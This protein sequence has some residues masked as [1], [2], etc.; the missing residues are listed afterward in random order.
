MHHLWKT[1]LKN[2]HVE[3]KQLGLCP[4]A[5]GGRHG[6]PAGHC[7]TLHWKD[8]ENH[9]Q[10]HLPGTNRNLGG[11]QEQHKRAPADGSLTDGSWPRPLPAHTGQ[12]TSVGGEAPGPPRSASRH[13]RP[14][15]H[16][17]TVTHMRTTWLQAHTRPT[18]HR[19]TRQSHT[20]PWGIAHTH[21]FS[22]GRLGSSTSFSG[23]RADTV[24]A[25]SPA[26]TAAGTEIG[27]TQNQGQ[28]LAGH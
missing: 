27:R 26:V 14:C 23:N 21:R 13:K 12:G 2:A 3:R 18:P 11:I 7:R 10:A 28:A 17:A 20:C 1:F 6:D 9:Q 5:L 24:P 22:Q 16:T 4:C 8:L 15:V 25:H 19:P